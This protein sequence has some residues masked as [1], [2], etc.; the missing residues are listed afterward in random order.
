MP[1]LIVYIEFE[2]GYSIIVQNHNNNYE[3]KKK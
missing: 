1:F 3:F 2:L